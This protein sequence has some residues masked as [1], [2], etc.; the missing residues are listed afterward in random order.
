VTLGFDY[1][2]TNNDLLFGG[3]SVFPTSTEIFQLSAGYGAGIDD[4]LGST[5]WMVTV[6]ASPGGLSS[7]NEDEA[8]ASQRTD[9]RARY[10]YGKLSV[11][12][13][14]R[15]PH[16]FSWSTQASFQAAGA[17]LLPSEEMAF[18]GSATLR[19]F[20]EQ[21]AIRDNG[22]LAETELSVRPLTP[23]L[24]GRLGFSGVADQLTL[25]AFIDYG[26]GWDRDEPPGVSSRIKLASAGPGLR[27]QA[28][29]N[30][31]M[32]LT[33]GAPLLT[34]GPVALSRTQFAVDL[35]L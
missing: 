12:R 7:E 4:R 30:F 33:Y 11:A 20:A 22:F 8:F 15:L 9:A 6:T 27:Y 26:Y 2:S 10:V 5:R 34:R 16:G 23:G 31:T 14:F 29:R 25:F 35:A 13:N 32:R 1:K 28:G 21:A 19:G 3:I 18:G 24:P 17:S